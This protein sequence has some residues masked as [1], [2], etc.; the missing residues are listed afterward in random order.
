MHTSV[1]FD[2]DHRWIVEIQLFPNRVDIWSVKISSSVP[3]LI[4]ERK[5]HSA[6]GQHECQAGHEKGRT[7]PTPH[8]FRSRNKLQYFTFLC[9]KQSIMRAIPRS[10]LRIRSGVIWHTAQ[11]FVASDRGK[12][13]PFWVDDVVYSLLSVQEFSM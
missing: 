9:H 6:G 10:V 4:Q 2:L 3:T 1:V 12:V 7:Y 8:V 5:K 13:S 11:T